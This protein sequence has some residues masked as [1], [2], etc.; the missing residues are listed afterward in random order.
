MG[1][2]D[3]QMEVGG[4]EGWGAIIQTLQYGGAWSQKIFFQPFRPQFGLK[5]RGGA[6]P[7]LDPPLRWSL[8]TPAAL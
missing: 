7:P 5:I 8:K 2:P 1:D 3:L 6:A 4:G